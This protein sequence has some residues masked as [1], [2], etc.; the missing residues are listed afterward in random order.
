MILVETTTGEVRDLDTEWEQLRDQAEMLRPRRP[1]TP[2]ELDALLRDLEDMGFAIADF[3]RA[4][5]DARY[6][7]EVAYSNAQNAA[8]AR[9]SETA[10]S[11]TLARAMA[12]LDASDAHAALLHTKAVFHHAEDINR[13]LGRKHFGLMNTN[14]GIQGM[15]SNWHR[16][17]P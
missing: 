7:A 12:E 8:L 2:L 13:A 3:L 5:N 6:D 16:R 4:V 1:E 10:R 11:V 15:T 14:K 17:T 9:H